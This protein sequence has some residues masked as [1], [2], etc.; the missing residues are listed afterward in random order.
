MP[1]EAKNRAKQTNQ[2]EQQCA[3]IVKQ[4]GETRRVTHQGFVERFSGTGD[5]VPE[6]LKSDWSRSSRAV[7]ATLNALSIAVAASAD[8]LKLVGTLKPA[9]Y[10]TR[11][12]RPDEDF[13]A[14]QKIGDLVATFLKSEQSGR[15]SVFLG[16]GST[17]YHVG[18]KMAEHGP[19]EG[20]LFWTVNIP[21]AAA[22]VRVTSLRSTRSVFQRP[23]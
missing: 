18:L 12:F 4:L 3:W 19:Y 21:L 22:C 14:K 13:E 8:Q 2:V 20:R 17:I 5:P 11:R 10:T 15:V 7:A 6:K 23:F 16:S 1:K 9:R